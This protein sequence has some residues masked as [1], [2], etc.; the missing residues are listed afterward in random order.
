MSNVLYLPLPTEWNGYEVNTWFQVG[1]QVHLVVYDKQLTDWE[2]SNLLLSLLFEEEAEDGS[3][4]MRDYPKDQDE[5]EECI[6]WYLSGWNHDH[7]QESTDKRRFVDYEAD[8]WRIYA[9]FRQIYGIDLS[10]SDMHW[11]EFQG[12]LWNMP[13]DRS[14][15]LKVVDIR[16]KEITSKMGKEEKEAIKKA[17]QVYAIDQPAVKKEYSKQEEE[18]IDSYDQRMRKIKER[19]KAVASAVEEFRRCI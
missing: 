2:K 1:I 19:K 13:D 3:T 7:F 17:K 15:F 6:K 8:Q 12:L 16:R 9:D 10:E 11:W 14:A 5:L 4:Y 18:K